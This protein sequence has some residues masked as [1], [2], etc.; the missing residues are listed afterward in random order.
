M[1]ERWHRVFKAAIM[2]H[3]DA[4]WS[5]V[6]ST[7]L[8]GLR[9]HVCTTLRLPGEFF[10]P[11]DISPDPNFF[12]EEFREYMRRVRPVPVVHKHAKR[13]FY[14]KELHNCSHVFMRNVAKKAL[15]RPYSGPHRILQRVSD[16]VFNIDVNGSL[17]PAHFVPDNLDDVSVTASNDSAATSR[18]LNLRG[19][20]GSFG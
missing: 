14:F 5:R 2:C 4:S 7:V 18:S 9:S 1:I 15:G 19:G 16:R 11:E 12:F 6:L 8:L 20:F 10:L 13:A 3:A 17:K